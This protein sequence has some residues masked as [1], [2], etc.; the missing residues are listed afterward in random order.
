[1][2]LSYVVLL[3]DDVP[4]AVRFWQEVMRLPLTFRDDTNDFA[5]FD[6]GSAGLTLSIYSR[7]GLTTLLGE[8]SPAPVGRQMY[9][10]FPV[11]DVDSAYSDLVER[12]AT[13]IATPRD[14]AV[15]QARL[16][17]FN[18]PDGHII[19]IAGPMRGPTAPTV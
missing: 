4:A 7:S 6:T 13:P 9:L 10:S 1:M 18:S 2:K 12:G 16:A 14:V 19:E 11:D 17:H 3:S 5:A 8:A 15:Q